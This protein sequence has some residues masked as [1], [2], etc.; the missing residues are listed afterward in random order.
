M[1]DDFERANVRTRPRRRSRSSGAVLNTPVTASSAESTPTPNTGISNGER[2][3]LPSDVMELRRSASADHVVG[4]GRRLSRSGFNPFSQSGGLSSSFR[5]NSAGSSF[6]AGAG[7]PVSSSA[8]RS[9]ASFLMMDIDSARQSVDAHT[10]ALSFDDEDVMSDGGRLTRNMLGDSTSGS[11]G[12]ERYRRA[13]SLDS[14]PP[15]PPDSTIS[16]EEVIRESMASALSSSLY[17][18]K[19]EFLLPHQRRSNAVGGN[20]NLSMA[21]T[22]SERDSL[23]MS[24]HSRDSLAFSFSSRSTFR[25]STISEQMLYETD[26]FEPERELSARELSEVLSGSDEDV[27]SYEVT[28]IK[29]EEEDVK[30]ENAKS[31]WA[32][33]VKLKARSFLYSTVAGNKNGASG[34]SNGAVTSTAPTSAEI[35]ANKQKQILA[36]MSSGSGFGAISGTSSA[37]SSSSTH[38][39]SI[40]PPLPSFG[41]NSNGGAKF[42][43]WNRWMHDQYQHN[44]G[45]VMQRAFKDEVLQRQQQQ[46]AF[47]THQPTPDPTAL[48]SIEEVISNP[49]MMRYYAAW[50]PDPAD[51]SKLFFLCS[52]E[53]YR[54]FWC[55]LRANYQKKPFAKDDVLMLRTY[56]VKIAMKYLAKN[57]Q[58][59]INGSADADG[60]SDEPPIVDSNK[61]R[62]IKRDLAAGGEDALRTFDDVAVKVKR[63]LM[64]KF[65]EFRK[66]ELYAEMQKTVEREVIC[67]EDILMNHR[68]AN[69]FW[70]FLFPHNYHREIAL[71]LDVEYEFKPAFRIYM[72]LLKSSGS[73]RSAA[74]SSSTTNQRRERI[75]QAAYRCRRLLKYISQKY[76]AG[77]AEMHTLSRTLV[78]SCARLQ[79][80]QDAILTKFSLIH[81]ELYHRFLTSRA[82]AEFALYPKLSPEDEKDSIDDSMR[83]SALLLS[84]GLRAHHWAG[85]SSSSSSNG[86]T[87]ASSSNARDETSAPKKKSLDSLRTARS[88]EAISGVL[89]FEAVAVL[90]TAEEAENDTDENGSRVFEDPIELQVVQ[91]PL[92]HDPTP[93]V[94]DKSVENFLVPWS[95]DPRHVVL[96]APSCPAPLAFNFRMGDSSAGASAAELF[97]ACVV[98]YKPAPPLSRRALESSRLDSKSGCR[99][100]PY[101]VCVLSKFP[102]VDLLRER[103]AEAYEFILELETIAAANSDGKETI[104]HNGEHGFQLDKKV[105]AKLTR[106]VSKE[107]ISQYHQPSPL[108]ESPLLEASGLTPK[109]TAAS[110][111]AALPRL[112]H[113]V[114]LLFD[115]LDV[116]TVLLV[117]TAALLENR[118]LLVSSY[119]SVLMKVGESLRALMHPLSW[120]HVYLP[121]LPRRLLQYLECPTPFIFG[122]EKQAL[123]DAQRQL[124]EEGGDDLFAGAGEELLVVDLDKGAV[125]RGEVPCALP[126]SVRFDLRDA[127]Y[128]CLKPNVS[129]SDHVFA[130]HFPSKPL[131]FPE[132][133]V[134]GLFLRAVNKL[135]GDFG[136][137]RYV[138][139][140]EFA[141]KRTVFFDEA[142]YLAASTPEMREFRTLFIAT[143]AFSE[144]AVTHHGFEEQPGQN[145]TGASR[146]STTSSS[147][148]VSSLPRK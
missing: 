73:S 47:P 147:S 52:F 105:L 43:K 146:S 21:G 4:S 14:S 25:R 20:L 92:P 126:D 134:R 116:S 106:S 54:Q 76:Y 19:D 110:L 50:L 48:I 81:L 95:A 11:T 34:S 16:A 75:E 145:C 98:L 79:A 57:A 127:L 62:S 60:G 83:L 37:A 74:L 89:T 94:V 143:Q 112:D 85:G 137:H 72:S 142:S 131:V 22:V 1:S 133:A 114:R 100:I 12:S 138:W 121:V 36:Q 107:H 49:R 44:F 78:T 86:S 46:F 125:L 148:S 128:E 27:N 124:I 135:I 111:L 6:R 91:H 42:Q 45:K 88:F 64:F 120:P 118:I 77:D 51:Q 108:P 29:E 61:L 132:V 101:G 122:A 40:L 68:F 139:T 15:L 97:A 117:F 35:W 119:L 140:D 82:Y 109:A 3:L 39:H 90:V 28:S 53:E 7:V 93:H 84:Y 123:D 9:H 8:L 2:T 130:H 103:L 70:I 141:R 104:P 24:R 38:H 26:L 59:P 67:L 71:W 144:F 80:E 41:Q 55:T 13:S 10:R 63:V 113:S 136:Y 129:R 30:L 99:W 5:L 56:G 17:T 66:T 33:H 31:R 115:T 65:P 18:D 87:S 58:F 23:A 69:F 102:M 96:T 32:Q